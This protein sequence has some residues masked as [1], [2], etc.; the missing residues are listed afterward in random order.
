MSCARGCCDTPRDHYLS[1]GISSAAMPSR[2]G[3]RYA[4]ARSKAESQ[5]SKD[6]VAYKSLT[7]SGVQPPQ[8]DGC[9]ELQAKAET[10]HEVEAGIGL[11]TQTQR[12]QLKQVMGE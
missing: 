3:A 2:Q 8:I 11:S 1:I 9:A 5:L 6:L 4:T 12:K 7:E 10:K